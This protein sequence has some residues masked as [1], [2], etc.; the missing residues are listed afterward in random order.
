MPSTASVRDL[1]NRFP[2]VRKLLETEGEVLLTESG[3]AKYRLTPYTAPR[4]KAAARVDYWARLTSSQP[5][6]MTAAQAQAL[7]EEN[8]GDR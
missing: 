7:H 4:G 5:T 3:R 1:R 2:Q 8:R 6:P